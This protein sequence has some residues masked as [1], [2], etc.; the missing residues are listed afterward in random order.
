M[1]IADFVDDAEELVDSYRKLADQKSIRNLDEQ[2][3]GF[4][5]SYD[6]IKASL[7]THQPEDYAIPSREFRTF[8]T[9]LD[10]VSGPCESDEYPA[11]LHKPNRKQ[12]LEITQM[13]QSYCREDSRLTA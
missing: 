9:K 3:L 5:R 7:A 8:I 2:I 6:R 10:A 12:I 11:V 4:N 13:L 1:L